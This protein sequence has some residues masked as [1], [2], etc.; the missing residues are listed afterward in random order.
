MVMRYPPS[1]P[2]NA[3]DVLSQQGGGG[4]T[5]MVATHRPLTHPEVRH[6]GASMAS[7]SNQALRK[8]STSGRAQK[9]YET[10]FKAL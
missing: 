3:K 10:L 4:D 6:Q 2:Q 8:D 1:Q 7:I 9:S 5:L